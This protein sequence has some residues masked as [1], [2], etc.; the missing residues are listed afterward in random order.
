MGGRLA[1]GDGWPADS[2]AAAGRRGAAAGRRLTESHTFSPQ[3]VT[4]RELATRD[5]L[6]V[7]LLQSET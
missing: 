5:S 4:F 1:T 2:W 3:N 6:E 7:T